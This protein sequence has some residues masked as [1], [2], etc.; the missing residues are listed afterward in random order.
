MMDLIYIWYG[1]IYWSKYFS[2]TI[3]IH[4]SDLQIKVTAQLT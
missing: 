4:V 1:D 2:S 3:A